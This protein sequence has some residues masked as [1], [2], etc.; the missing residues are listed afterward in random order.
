MS[1]SAAALRLSLIERDDLTDE[2]AFVGRRSCKGNVRVLSDA[3]GVTYERARQ[4]C[5]GE[6]TGFIC[7]ALEGMAALAGGDGTTGAHF[8]VALRVTMLKTL[9]RWQSEA[10]LQ[11]RLA[12]WQA[13]EVVAAARRAEQD[14]RDEAAVLQAER[15]H[16]AAL[17]EIIATREALRQKLRARRSA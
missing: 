2:A 7:R 11:Q 17:E 5:Q 13:R 10:S 1:T 16:A 15:D 3:L 8:L 6:R 12:E 14:E 9:L 4:L